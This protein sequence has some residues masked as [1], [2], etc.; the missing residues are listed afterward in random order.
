MRAQLIEAGASPAAADGLLGFIAW[1]GDT[2]Q[3]LAMLEGYRGRDARFDQGLDE[4]SAVAGYLRAF[5]VPDTHFA[6]DLTIARGLDYYTGTV[7]ETTM[8]AHPEIGSIC[9]GGRYDDLAGYYTGRKLPGVGISI[10]VTRLF[11]VL[12]EQGL[13]ADTPPAAPADVL[14]IPMDD[15]LDYPIRA[16]T[17]LR[18]AGI[19]TQLYCESRKLKAKIAYADK[20]HIPYAVF[21]GEQ[22]AAEGSVTIKDLRSGEQRREPLEAACARLSAALAAQTGSVIADI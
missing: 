14:V 10:G 22:E 20:L 17:A 19:R 16:T 8:T 1:K 12:G 11:Y 6:I 4:L 18:A 9:S 5:G 13:L 3:T 15:A 2:A 21:I 7:Y